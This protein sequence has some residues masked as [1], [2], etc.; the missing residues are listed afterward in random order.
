MAHNAYKAQEN[1][2]AAEESEAFAYARSFV[3]TLF[4]NGSGGKQR[5]REEADYGIDYK[6]CSPAET[7][8]GEHRCCAPCCQYRRE[9]R[10]YCLYKLAE[11]EGRGEF[12]AADKVG[13]ERV[14]RSLHYGVAD[15]E[16][17]E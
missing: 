4:L 14:Q 5:Y 8:G 3:G 16:E 6:E 7:E 10:C 11:G 13:Y 9:E 15:A 1:E 12:V 2:G 17:G